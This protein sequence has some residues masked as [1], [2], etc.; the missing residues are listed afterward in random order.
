MLF[1]LR[2]V[3]LA[4]VVLPQEIRDGSDLAVIFVAWLRASRPFSSL[5]ELER[6][7]LGNIDWVRRNVGDACVEVRA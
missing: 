5:E 6:V 3:A 1:H 4:A 7:V 2:A